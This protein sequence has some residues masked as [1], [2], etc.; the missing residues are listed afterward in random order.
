M[1]VLEYKTLQ[2]HSP[3]N[4]PGPLPSP[5]P[6]DVILHMSGYL[7]FEDYINFVRA[8]WPHGDEDDSV[9]NKLWQLS[10]RSIILE[11]C[12]GK[13]LKVEYNYDPDRETED[14][15]LINVENLLPTFGGAVPARWEFVSVSQLKGFIKR[16]VFFSKY[17]WARG[18]FRNEENTSY[19]CKWSTHTSKERS[20]SHP[21]RWKHVY[22]W[23]NEH[24]EPMITRRHQNS[25]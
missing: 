15:I 2:T 9:R 4:V 21:F 13:P 8:L 11:F 14:R 6:Y 18:A 23:V 16:E 10:T 19:T 17:P 1:K 7:K 25:P 3:E 12:N 22:W 20:Q 5:F 24:L